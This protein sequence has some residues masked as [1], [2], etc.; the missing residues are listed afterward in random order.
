[1]KRPQPIAADAV[2]RI[3]SFRVLAAVGDEKLRAIAQAAVMANVAFTRPD[4]QDVAVPPVPVVVVLTIFQTGRAEAP[5]FLGQVSR[6][7]GAGQEPVGAGRVQAVV[8]GDMPR[9]ALAARR[10]ARPLLADVLDGGHRHAV[11]EGVDGR[12]RVVVEMPAAV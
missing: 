5:V 4:V 10:L 9:L 7:V 12:H 8:F 2:A 3:H 1:M 6:A 11:A